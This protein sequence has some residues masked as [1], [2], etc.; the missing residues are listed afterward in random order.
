MYHN[1]L[2]IRNIPKTIDNIT[3]WPI[4]ENYIFVLSK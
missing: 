2:H 4:E 3:I 1:E